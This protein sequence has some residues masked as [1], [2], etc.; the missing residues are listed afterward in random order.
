[1]GDLLVRKMNGKYKNLNKCQNLRL[2]G[3]TIGRLKLEY[4]EVSNTEKKTGLSVSDK[5]VT[6]L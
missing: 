2:R 3:V 5:P 4:E 6:G 1:M